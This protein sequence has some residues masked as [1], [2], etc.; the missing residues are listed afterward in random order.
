MFKQIRNILIY[1]IILIL[2]VASALFYRQAFLVMLFLMMC[3]LPVFSVLF[4]K[5]AF[6][7]LTAD[8]TSA[9]Y[10]SEKGMTVPLTV[11][12]HNP[13]PFPL[14]HVECTL[15]ILSPFYPDKGN[16][17]Y[18]LPA[19]AKKA[20]PFVLPVTYAHCGLFQAKLVSVKVYDYL[21]FISLSKESDSHRQVVILPDSTME[22]SYHPELYGEGFDEYESSVQRGNISSNVTDIRE[23][24][25]GDRLQKI[26]WKLSAKI[27]KL[28]VKENEA[29]SSHQ[30]FVL[31][32]LYH[33]TERPQLLD[34]AIEYAYSLSKELLA[35]HEN[36]LFGF[37]SAGAGEFV[38]YPVLTEDDLISALCEAFYEPPYNTENLGREIYENS[39][40][41]KGTLLQVTYKG[42][43]NEILEKIS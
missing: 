9:S 21:H 38:S 10:Q 15:S 36:F 5:R 34:T 26:H 18:V 35:A 40:L 3:L 12:L 22:V 42:V 4:T 24:L 16:M 17:V 20:T 33:D 25:P 14:L 23:Y 30:F 19:S 2:L 29:T 37:Y 39:G 13:T 11:T 32:E 41:I 6:Q 7:S 43:S 1:G 31:L 8:I 28:M 27:D